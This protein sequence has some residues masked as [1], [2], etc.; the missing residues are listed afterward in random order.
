M[1]MVSCKCASIICLSVD[2]HIFQCLV[3]GKNKGTVFY[4]KDLS[5]LCRKIFNLR[6][7]SACVQC[8]F[9]YINI[10][11]INTVMAP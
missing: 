8:A 2:F 4:C 10:I 6:F 5:T 11:F 1:G 9:T 7:L 3:Q